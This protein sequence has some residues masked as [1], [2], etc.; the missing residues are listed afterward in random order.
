MKS[1]PHKELK[2]ICN[3]LLLS[4]G[5]EKSIAQEVTDCLIQTSLRGVDSH[6]IRL[7]PH[8]IRVAN[9]G[10]I[11]KNSLCKFKQTSPTTGIYDADHTY[12]HAAASFAMNEAIKMADNSGSGFVVVKN[13]THFSACAY[14]ALKASEND[15]M[16][17]AS[18]ST[19]SM[20]VP[21]RGKRPYL[22]TNPISFSFPC[23]GE[24]PVSLD[25]A[26]TQVA[27]NRVLKAK[28]EGE[29]LD[30]PWAINEFGD[31]TDNPKEAIGLLPAG[32][33]KGYGLGLLVD[34]LCSILANQP[35]GPHITSMFDGNLCNKR[36]LS[37]FLGAIKISNFIDIKVFK[38]LLKNMITEIRNEPPIDKDLPILV[39]GDKEK[40]SEEKR[41]KN[42]IP[43]ESEIINEINEIIQQQGLSDI[44]LIH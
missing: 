34:I 15:M 10:R 25:M 11:N 42:G 29:A 39:A 32:L 6:G 8:Y 16:G 2:N 26:T 37:H 41:L 38:T 5:I 1:Y 23:E 43:I 33:H 17:I 7:L 40:L 13:S 30:F 9:S 28:D 4:T 22:G 18:T 3:K 21:T 36:Y 24:S 44:Y 35:Y 20:M 14:Y 27:W 31:P 19:S 12:G